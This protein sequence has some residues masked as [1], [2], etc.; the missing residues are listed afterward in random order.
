[1]YVYILLPVGLAAVL[2]L[3]DP[4]T[5]ATEGGVGPSEGDYQNTSYKLIQ[6]STPITD[7]MNLIINNV[8]LLISQYLVGFTT[9]SLINIP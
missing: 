3:G 7:K 5:G 9:W 1:M 2:S 6:E 8:V 4:P